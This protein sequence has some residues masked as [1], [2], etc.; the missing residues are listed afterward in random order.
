ML[1]KAAWFKQN[2]LINECCVVTTD[3][4]IP[5]NQLDTCRVEFT[6]KDSKPKRFLLKDIKKEVKYGSGLIKIVIDLKSS[7][8]KHGNKTCSIFTE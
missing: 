5:H 3:K 4:I 1:V 2:N 7:K 8:L 6:K